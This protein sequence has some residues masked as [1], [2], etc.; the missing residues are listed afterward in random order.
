[1]K[2]R[3]DIDGLRAVAVS[4][5]I[6]AHAGV[7]AVGGGF[8]GVDV[9]F[10]I[11]GY[12]ITTILL[13]DLSSGRY[14]LADFYERRARRILP[15]LI[16]VISVCFP[17]SAW[18]M[19]P[20]F[21]QN[22]GQSVVATLLFANNILLA[23]TSGYWDLESSFKPLLHT[24][25]LGV[26]EQYYVLFPII[27][28]FTWRYGKKNQIVIVSLIAVLS[29]LTA[30]YGWRAYPSANFYLPTSRAWELMLGSLAAFVIRKDRPLDGWI[31]AAGLLTVV[32]SMFVFTEHTPSPSIFAAIPVIGT[33][34]ILLFNR[35]GT[36]AYRLLSVRPL[37]AIGL[38]SYS[39]YL[40]HQPLFAFA[41]IAMK[42]PPNAAMMVF[43]VFATFGIAA[44]SWR[45]IETP[46][47]RREFIPLRQFAIIAA[48]A[49]A[50]L[51]SLGLAVHVK[52]GFPTW[53]F[54]N[55]SN[56]DVYISYNERIR[57]YQS[58]NFPSNGMRNIALIGNSYGRDVGNILIEGGAVRR[59]NLVYLPGYPACRDRVEYPD[60]AGVVLSKADI[61]IVALDQHNAVDKNDS[62]A[63]PGQPTKC[64][65]D[66][67]KAIRRHTSA[68]IVYFG[69]KQF[70]RNINPFGRVAIEERSNALASVPDVQV[71]M[72][73]EVRKNLEKYID[74]IR[75]LGPDGKSVRFFDDNGNPMSPDRNHLTKYGAKFI[76]NRLN[77]TDPLPWRIIKDPYCCRYNKSLNSGM[78]R[79]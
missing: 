48:A 71:A 2:Y 76:S 13:K 73:N 70:G 18:L 49:T 51:V 30:E 45:Y 40:W 57:S 12:L 14:S 25:S 59:K 23:K 65:L 56:S 24:W 36:I 21:F 74:V 31:S 47:R 16:V 75:I 34:A 42:N 27:L 39:A 72:N 66:I 9:F 62:E 20:D 44:L 11:S 7:A 63:Q 53:T 15:A 37:V 5:V 68:E 67:E 1:M 54:P 41:R 26:E 64:A 28:S 58:K 69:S 52:Q 33:I 10:A 55:V 60:W 79:P 50:V 19:L 46:F 61:V 4:S 22:F 78:M 35:P 17:L 77:E 38:I 43:L 6:L 8:L 32:A 29:L 3:S